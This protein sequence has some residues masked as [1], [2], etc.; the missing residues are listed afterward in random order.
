VRDITRKA[1]ANT[2]WLLHQGFIFVRN[3]EHLARRSIS[4]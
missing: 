4:E 3:D 1:H 2:L